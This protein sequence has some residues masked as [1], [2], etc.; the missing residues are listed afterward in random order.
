ME[1]KCRKFPTD[2]RLLGPRDPVNRS[3]AAESAETILVPAEGFEPRPTVYK[4]AIGCSRGLSINHLQRLPA[5]LPG[6]PLT[7]TAHPSWARHV[8][9]TLLNSR[10]GEADL[11]RLTTLLHSHV[12]SVDRDT[13]A[14]HG[15]DSL[16]GFDCFEY[17]ECL[18]LDV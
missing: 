2:Q 18:D 15:Q 4:A 12:A 16:L 3:Q 11:G 9:G 17:F 6:P 14:L 5:P 7:M 1:I 10:P 13:A 8:P